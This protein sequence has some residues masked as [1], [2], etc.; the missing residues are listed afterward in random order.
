MRLC[1]AQGRGLDVISPAKATSYGMGGHSV[2]ARHRS[3]RPDVRMP[4][5]Q[6]WAAKKKEEDRKLASDLR[7]VKIKKSERKERTVDARV[8]AS[9]PCCVLPLLLLSWHCP[10]RR[11]AWRS[12]N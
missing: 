12:P 2:T 8:F 9:L 7:V 3:K 10:C 6:R 5:K 11:C 1:S 4:P